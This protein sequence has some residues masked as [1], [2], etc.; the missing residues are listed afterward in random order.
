[1]PHD[2]MV[3]LTLKKWLPKLLSTPPIMPVGKRDD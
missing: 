1:M 2:A 3:A